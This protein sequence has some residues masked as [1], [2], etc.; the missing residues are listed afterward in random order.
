ME[1][2]G[3]VEGTDGESLEKQASEGCPVCGNKNLKR[4]GAL[5]MCPTHGSEPWEKKQE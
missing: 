5:L 1:K 4:H 2:F 3:V